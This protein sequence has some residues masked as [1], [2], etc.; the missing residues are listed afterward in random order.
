MNRR[1]ATTIARLY[2][3]TGALI[4]FVGL[5]SKAAVGD[6]RPHAKDWTRFPPAD[7]ASCLKSTGITGSYTDLLTCL[8]IKRDARQLSK[9]PSTA[10]QGAS[11]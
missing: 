7:R 6:E 3:A 2:I 9:Q 10:G 1:L 11:P 8:E 5:F 4:L